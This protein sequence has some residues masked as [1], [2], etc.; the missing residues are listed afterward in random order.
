MKELLNSKTWTSLFLIVA[1]VT[2]SYGDPLPDDLDYNKS[3]KIYEA[4][5]AKSVADR[6]QANSAL[7]KAEQIRLSLDE[8]LNTKESLKMESAQNSREISNLKAL[9]PRLQA[10]NEEMKREISS[11]QNR[12]TG[13]QQ[14]IAKL[15]R[16][17]TA[18][19]QEANTRHAELVKLHTEIANHER[20][21]EAFRQSYERDRVEYDRAADRLERIENILRAGPARE[22]EL[23]R[24][25]DELQGRIANTEQRI[26]ELSRRHQEF[27]SR[28]QELEN[29]VRRE[30]QQ[31]QPIQERVQQLTGE[32]RQ[33]QEQAQ[34]AQAVRQQAEQRVAQSQREH[35]EAWSIVERLRRGVEE[36]QSRL[37]GME[38]EIQR[39]THERNVRS[40]RSQEARREMESIRS[41]CPSLPVGCEPGEAARYVDLKNESDSLEREVLRLHAQ[42]VELQ[43]TK[44]RLEDQLRRGSSELPAAEQR[45][46][47]ASNEVQRA[48]ENRREAQSELEQAQRRAE[49]SANQLE[50]ARRELEAQSRELREAQNQLEGARRELAEIDNGIR[51]ANER[52]AE[53]RRGL[54]ELQRELVE[55]ER[56]LDRARSEL[57]PARDHHRRARLELENSTQA[58]RDIE[59]RRDQLVSEYRRLDSDYQRVLAELQQIT[60]ELDQQNQLVAGLIES[61]R[62]LQAQITENEKQIPISQKRIATLETRNTQIVR[63]L[64]AVETRIA[65]LETLEKTALLD[66]AN[67]DSLAQQSES[68]A[69]QKYQEYLVVKRRFDS[70]I[71][72]AQADG[73]AQGKIG[74]EFGAKEGDTDGRSVGGKNGE[75]AGRAD[76]L[77]FGLEQGREAGRR[78]GQDKGYQDGF[79]EPKNFELGRASGLVRGD[80]DADTEAQSEF[81]N[82]MQHKRQEI[83]QS[84]LAREVQLDNLTSSGAPSGKVARLMTNVL[85]GRHQDLIN[86]NIELSTGW[87]AMAPQKTS[88]DICTPDKKEF[89]K[90]IRLGQATCSSR[91]DVIR[92]A[93]LVAYNESYTTEF[94]LGYAQAYTP[95]FS[96]ACTASYDANFET[97][98]AVRYAEGHT[99]TYGPTYARANAEGATAAQ[100][101]GFLAGKTEGYN[102]SIAIKKQHYFSEGQKA[103]T[104][105]FQENPVVKLVQASVVKMSEGSSNAIVAGDQLQVRLSLA[106]FGQVASARGQVKAKLVA[107]TP[108]VSTP[109]NQGWVD[110]VGLPGETLS[111][112]Q[113]VAVA[114]IQPGI[115]AEDVSLKVLV[116]LADGEIVEAPIQLRTVEHVT[117]V[118]TKIDGGLFD[119]N[120]YLKPIVGRDQA[121]NVRVKNESVINPNEDLQI[122]LTAAAGVAAGVEIVKGSEKINRRHFSPGDETSTIRLSYKVKSRDLVGKP[123][124]MLLKVKYKGNISMSTT[125]T[126]VPQE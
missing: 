41:N 52:L 102:R 105:F 99:E 106:N 88:K 32:N 116:Q 1:L 98:K 21:L 47:R 86:A 23:R 56:Q 31:L 69:E 7:A 82:G 53:L 72:Q 25:R 120:G 85:T 95:G 65:Q 103:A 3:Q 44:G 55:L 33:A 114:H 83:L 94:K 40:G 61:V 29:R 77:V 27:S 12:I 38:N 93:C 18:V 64:A 79:N 117:V 67:R 8:E 73:R 9:I 16:Q 74:F 2:P 42:V 60:A 57:G 81:P 70:L 123:V 30:Q 101:N 48:E 17:Q 76:G 20:S 84:K 11:T 59:A 125:F 10:D 43:R 36:A 110:V 22:Q 62:A 122:E 39:L 97:N 96:A 90:A 68:F 28:A 5:R 92:D 34:R 87:R 89:T 15:A 13:L 4:A 71:A 104:Q 121:V 49:Q 111:H 24:N 45:F 78:E 75:Q 118:L 100:N 80:Q 66:F 14:E 112:V 37:P 119:K 46:Q 26:A 19:G 115:G 6:A 63:E 54:P 91:Y 58:I 35:Q 109:A 126:A 113:N 124:M 107:L 50:V 108:N 51:G